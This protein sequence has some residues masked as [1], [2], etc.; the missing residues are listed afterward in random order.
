MASLAFTR[1]SELA[2]AHRLSVYDAAYSRERAARAFFQCG[3]EGA[4]YRQ[5]GGS[6]T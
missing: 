4:Q 1:L 2:A 5:G 3:F 6:G